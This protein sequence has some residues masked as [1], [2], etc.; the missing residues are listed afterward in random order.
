MAS[1]RKRAA[2]WQARVTRKGYPDRVKTFATRQDA[3]RWA[4]ATEA[5]MD[6][7]AYLDRSV[8]ERTSLGDILGR[9]A[10]EV[11]PTKRGAETELRRLKAMQ[12]HPI[13]KLSMAA[14]RPQDV[15]DYRDLRLRS[16]QG[17]TANRE[18]QLLGA[19]VNHAMREWRVPIAFNPVEQVRKPHPGRGRT[20]IFEGDEE[21][22]LLRALNGEGYLRVPR[23]HHNPWVRPVVEL[24][25]ETACRR[26][27]LLAMRWEHVDLSRR[28]IRLPLTKNG[29]ERLVPLSVRAIA[30]IQAL[31]RSLD[32]R[33]FPITWTALHQAFK[34]AC[35][36]AGIEDF[37]FHD[38][39]HVAIT[40]LAT[41]LPNVIE[42]AA[43]T[44]HKTLAMLHRYYHARP[45]DLARK[46]G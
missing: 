31:P 35:R 10:G 23:V 32:G 13:A 22:R 8:A 17:S 6:R 11:S 7:G 19:V 9:Y 4:R 5:E 16:I 36:R 14:L 2:R 39:R 43:V 29:E 41:K 46:L 3:E 15:A 12:R 18:L 42:L 34:K 30:L 27:E 45:E 1:I 40:R 37:H 21:E 33:L 26:G 25:L 20:R 44:G 28:V 38:L 24:A